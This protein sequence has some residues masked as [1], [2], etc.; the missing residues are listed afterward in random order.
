MKTCTNNHVPQ[1]K[2]TG[3]HEQGPCIIVSVSLCSWSCLPLWLCTSLCVT[4]PEYL[5]QTF[6]SCVLGNLTIKA[7][8]EFYFVLLESCLWVLNHT[9]EPDISTFRFA[10]FCKRSC[11]MYG[12]C[13]SVA[14]LEELYKKN[15]ED[16]KLT[17]GR[18]EQFHEI[19]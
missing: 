19:I 16:Q 10:F 15:R 3:S 11:H 6:F 17:G 4:V 8:L 7:V 18:S 5:H 2:K 1:I 13:F 9:A 12:M 14:Q